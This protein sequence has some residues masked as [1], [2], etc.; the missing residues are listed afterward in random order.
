MST[1]IKNSTVKGGGRRHGKGVYGGHVSATVHGPKSD[2]TY[3]VGGNSGGK[4]SA[5]FN[6]KW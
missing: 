3:T 6:V 5:G 2:I 4:V 1:I